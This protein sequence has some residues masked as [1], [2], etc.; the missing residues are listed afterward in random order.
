M[1][2][3]LER[4]FDR[5]KWA[6]LTSPAHR[7]GL[8]LATRDMATREKVT[9]QLR[10]PRR[11]L[12][13][14][15]ETVRFLAVKWIADEKLADYR[16]D[17]EKAMADP[18]L[19]VRMYMACATAL[20]RIDGKEV[21]EKSLAD[22][23]AKRLADDSTAPAQRAM[24]LRQVPATHP[25]LTVE[26]LAKLLKSD[27]AGLKMEAVRALVEHPSKKRHDPLL[28]VFRSTKLDTHL[29]AY[30]MLGLTDRAQDLADEVY[31]IAKTRES[32]LRADA[33]RALIGVRLKKGQL[34]DLAMMERGI[35][36]SVDPRWSIRRLAYAEADLDKR[37]YEKTSMG[38]PSAKDIDAWLKRLEGKADSDSGARV[39]FHPKLGGCYKCHRIDGR[40]QDVGPDLSNIGNTDRRHIL[41]SIL[42]PSAN[43]A[44]H[45]VAWHL[46]TAAGKVRNGMLLH[47]NLDEYTYLDAKGERFKLKTG[48]LV[49]Q[50][51]TAI[52]IM[53]EG[54]V[55]TMT[56]QEVRD[57]L[58]Y[59]QAR[60]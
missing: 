46:E 18:K 6:D 34:D 26:L 9:S 51:P 32:P 27:D 38:R 47:T 22:Y 55:D 17:I 20:A 45:Y 28:K 10:S 13:D 16:P 56:D 52:S 49:E 57:L 37:P 41:E 21:S 40:G 15:D 39:F 8:L 14:P 4:N 44:P 12:N 30:A 36:E 54:L 42:Q 3:D 43:V 24:L 19:S 33:L 31:D 59:L 29:R 11:F 58:A 2:M 50:R 5:V 35:Q 53:P 7:I 48:D 1:G 60:K 25:K 23:F